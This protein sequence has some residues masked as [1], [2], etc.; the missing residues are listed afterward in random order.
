MPIRENAKT[1]IEKPRRIYKN[2]ELQDFDDFLHKKCMKTEMVDGTEATFIDW[3]E[4]EIKYGVRVRYETPYP[5]TAIV[6]RG[7]RKQDGAQI[8]PFE[9]FQNK[10]AQ[11]ERFKYGEEKRDERMQKTSEEIGIDKMFDDY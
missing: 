2:S 7:K 4:A 9:E 6:I 8:N 5:H 10:R 1:K 11:W 3:E